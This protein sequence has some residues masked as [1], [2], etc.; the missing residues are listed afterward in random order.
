MRWFQR[1]KVFRKRSR[2]R[3]EPVIPDWDGK[4]STVTQPS[5]PVPVFVQCC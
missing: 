4:A 5:Y 3:S 1:G 2:A